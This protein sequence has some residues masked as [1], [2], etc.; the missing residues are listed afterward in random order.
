MPL[1]ANNHEKKTLYAHS[2]V[3]AKKI[4]AQEIFSNNTECYK[5]NICV[6]QKMQACRS[7]SRRQHLPSRNQASVIS[8]ALIPA[9]VTT[10]LKA[11]NKKSA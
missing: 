8:Q 3:R 4:T 2:N 10:K 11:K 5:N 1:E 9:T 6:V 7:A